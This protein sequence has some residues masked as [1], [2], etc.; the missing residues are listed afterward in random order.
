MQSASKRVTASAWTVSKDFDCGL[1]LLLPH[2]VCTQA[3]ELQ[4]ATSCGVAAL[5]QAVLDKKFELER[6]EQCVYWLSFVSR[7]CSS[8]ERLLGTQ[9]AESLQVLPSRT[10]RLMRVLV[11][12]LQ[13]MAGGASPAGKRSP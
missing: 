12:H 11:Y 3:A 10:R 4:G 8:A 6:L 7:V 2:M 13:E 1:D 9:I 5:E